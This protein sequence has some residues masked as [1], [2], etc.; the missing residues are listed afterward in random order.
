MFGKV[1]GIFCI[2]A[3]GGLKDQTAAFRLYGVISRMDDVSVYSRKIAVRKR[4][5][6]RSLDGSS[7]KMPR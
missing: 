3:G 7:D 2:A 4:G 5:N 6:L 1:P